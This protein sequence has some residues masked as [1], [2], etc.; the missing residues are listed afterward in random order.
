MEYINLEKLATEVIS[1][2]VDALKAYGIAKEYFKKATDALKAIEAEA[3]DE[4]ETYEKNFVLDGFKF[5][6]RNG[7][8]RFDFKHLTEW[9]D[10]KQELS[11]IE[12]KYKGAYQSFERGLK[13]VTDDGEVIELPKV[14]QSKDSLIVRRND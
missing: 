2:E 14:S 3:L 11:E 6:K 12:S 4:A 9:A 13:Q 1:G 5:E 8:R 7:A 10:K